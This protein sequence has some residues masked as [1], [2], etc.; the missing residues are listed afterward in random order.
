MSYWIHVAAA[1]H[2]DRVAVEAPERSLTYA[3]LRG[4]A[5]AGSGGLR[6][7][8]RVAIALPAGVDFVIA[9]HACLLASAA[10]VPIDL[11][12]SEHERA[13]RLAGADSV[14]SSPIRVPTRRPGKAAG[15]MPMLF[16]GD[17]PVAVMHTSGTTAAPK[18]VVLTHRNFV[19]SALG[20]AAALGLDPAERWLC[21]M[22]LTHVGGLSIAIRSA[23]YAT[24]AVVHGRFDTEVVLN[25]LMDPGRRITLVSLVPTMLARLLDAGLER[26]PTLRWAL[27]GGGPI[28]PALLERA[29]AAGVPVAP[30]YGM[31]EACSQIA[32]FGWPLAGVELR[33]A[34]DGEV[35]VRGAI[36]SD[37][38]VAHDGWLHTGD[39]GRFDQRDRLEIIGRKADTIVTGGENVSPSEV[40]ATLLEHPAVADAAV[41]P[42][43]DPEWGEAVVATVVLRDGATAEPEELRAHCSARLAG[44]KVPKAVQFA[45][46]LPRTASG[47]LLR[48]QL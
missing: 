35:L 10:A 48:R 26:P 9:F 2:P 43:A 25:D 19:A 5:L 16:G 30:T 13:Q 46:R 18:T 27:L 22:P 45:D 6:G 47:K 14:I 36:V 38:A 21:P 11:R 32:T 44:F 39:L 17:P 28:A 40:E 8:K 41:H 29:Q 23:I 12:L 3:Q 15:M 4:A 37:G 34:G 20:S 42:R 24:T 1:K 7:A 31:T 33:T